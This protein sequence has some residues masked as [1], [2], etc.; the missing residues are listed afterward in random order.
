V[1]HSVLVQIR[2]SLW[3]PSAGGDAMDLSPKLCVAGLSAIGGRSMV[4]TEFLRRTTA[5]PL[6]PLSVAK[7]LRPRVLNKAQQGGYHVQSES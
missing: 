3:S 2:S 1:A 6:S 4:R 7:H 5:K